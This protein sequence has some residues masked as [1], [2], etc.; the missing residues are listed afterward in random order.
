MPTV[1]YTS[2][3]A[4]LA[5]TMEKVCEDHVPYVITRSSSEPVVMISLSDFEALQ[6]T[7]YIMKSPANAARVAESIDEIEK[8]IIKQNKK[9]KKK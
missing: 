9:G 7:N 1:S 2:L 4:N 3:R 6:E 5:K 8:L